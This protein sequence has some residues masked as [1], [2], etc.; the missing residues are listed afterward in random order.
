VLFLLLISFRYLSLNP[1]LHRLRWSV[2]IRVLPHI[3]IPRFLHFVLECTLILSLDERRRVRHAKL[4][5]L[6]EL[7]SSRV[8]ANL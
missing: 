8:V 3:H 7:V 1:D 4:I 5:K 6:D 2:R